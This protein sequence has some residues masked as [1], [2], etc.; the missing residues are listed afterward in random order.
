M[1]LDE[2]VNDIE[3]HGTSEPVNKSE[4]DTPQQQEHEEATLEQI[5]LVVQQPTGSRKSTRTN[6]TS[7]MTQRLCD[8][9]QTK[10]N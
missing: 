6:K 7:S 8:F 3:E 9:M 5:R 2:T 1:P 10:R 4:Q